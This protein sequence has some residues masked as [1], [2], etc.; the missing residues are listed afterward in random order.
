MLRACGRVRAVNI[1]KGVPVLHAVTSARAI[2]ERRDRLRNPPNAVVDLGIDLK[3]P[4]A[5]ERELE[6]PVS[7][8]EIQ[9]RQSPDFDFGPA[10]AEMTGIDSEMDRLEKRRGELEVMLDFARAYRVDPIVRITAKYFNVSYSDIMSA[11]RTGYIIVPR[12]AAMYLAKKFTG[13]SLPEIG[14]RIGGRDH[15][16]ILHAVRRIEQLIEEKPAI[17]AHIEAISALIEA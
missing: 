13:K 2:R 7:E 6:V 17:K 14:R 3:R 9:P 1:I 10:F 16:T 15:T 4:K 12:H 11:R 5:S 8:P